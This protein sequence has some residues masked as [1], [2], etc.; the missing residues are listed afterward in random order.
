[1]SHKLKIYKGTNVEFEDK[2]PGPATAI[3]TFYESNK[4][5]LT[6]FIAVAVNDTIL[7]YSNYKKYYLYQIPNIDISEQENSIWVSLANDQITLDEALEKLN[8]VRD[9][10]VYLSTQSV[11][12]L[13]FE[14]R[15]E[16]EAF[17]KM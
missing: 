8:A 13:A 14:N 16:Q 4:K 11:E 2:L 5:P 17:I 10:G 1:M 3:E 7:L 9:T 12:L 6:P 15:N